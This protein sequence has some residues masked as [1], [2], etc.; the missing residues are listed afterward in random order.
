MDFSYVLVS[1]ET[2]K[3]YLATPGPGTYLLPSEFGIVRYP[4]NNQTTMSSR[5]RVQT[6]ESDDSN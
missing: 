6:K 5:H 1:N 3:V 4:I 2:V